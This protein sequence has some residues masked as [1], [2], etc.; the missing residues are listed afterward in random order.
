MK[1]LPIF[2]SI[3]SLLGLLSEKAKSQ[4]LRAEPIVDMRVE[5][6]VRRGMSLP[7]TAFVGDSANAVHSEKFFQ[8]DATFHTDKMELREEGRQMLN[9]FILGIDD[10]L[11]KIREQHPSEPLILKIKISQNTKTFSAHRTRIIYSYL[12]ERL[13][14]AGNVQIQKEIVKENS[15]VNHLSC[16]ISLSDFTKNQP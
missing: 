8:D 11:K 3:L 14:Q 12:I 13:V 15:K 5:K 16:A 4:A 6:V 1:L 10:D 2:I 9:H 7:A